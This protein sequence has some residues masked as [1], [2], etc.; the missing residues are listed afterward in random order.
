MKKILKWIGLAVVVLAVSGLMAFLYFI[1]PFMT[2]PPEEFSKAMKEAA[3]P[4]SDIADPLQR[5]IAERGRD[6]V[7]RTGCI[8]CHAANGPQGPDYARYLAGGGIKMYTPAGTFVSRN[9]TPDPETGL[10]RRSDDEVKRVLRS[11]LF[12]DGHVAPSSAMPWANFSNW[13]EEDRHAVVAYLRHLK[14]VRQKIP[15]PAHTPIAFDP[16]VVEKDFAF[17]DYALP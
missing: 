6:I 15:E 11:G 7:M 9:L 16:G 1:P 17:K 2:I 4:A 10:A 12:A 5:A 3:P 8:G 13:T 14:P